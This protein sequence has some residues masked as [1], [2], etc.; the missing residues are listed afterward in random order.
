MLGYFHRMQTQLSKLHV[1]FQ[2][3]RILLLIQVSFLWHMTSQTQHRHPALSPGQPVS[4][5]GCSSAAPEASPRAQDLSLPRAFLWRGSMQHQLLCR[6][7][8]LNITKPV[9]PE[10]FLWS[11]DYAGDTY[12]CAKQTACTGTTATTDFA[13]KGKKR[14]LL[15]FRRNLAPWFMPSSWSIISLPF[16]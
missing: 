14:L 13:W 1:L 2:P 9:S 11:K 6:G 4:K 16:F 15:P 10:G 7:W 3:T 5:T 12:Y 8:A